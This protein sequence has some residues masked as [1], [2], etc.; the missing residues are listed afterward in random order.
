MKNFFVTASILYLLG[1]KIFAFGFLVEGDVE[2]RQFAASGQTLEESRFNF[3]AKCGPSDWSVT[4]EKPTPLHSF[5]RV[6]GDGTNCYYQIRYSDSTLESIRSQDGVSRNE[7]GALVLGRMVPNYHTYSPMGVIWLTYC[8]SKYFSKFTGSDSRYNEVDVP[9]GEFGNGGEPIELRSILRPAIWKTM[10]STG[11]P[12]QLTILEAGRRR[13]RFQGDGGFLETKYPKP[14][15][16][17][18]TNSAYNATFETFEHGIKLPRSSVYQTYLPKLESAASSNDLYIVQEI[19][20]NT[21]RV[22]SLQDAE[23]L[24]HAFQGVALINDCRFIESPGGVRP[25]LYVSTSRFMSNVELLN[26]AVYKN[27]KPAPDEYEIGGVNS[28]ARRTFYIFLA[29]VAISGVIAFALKR[30]SGRKQQ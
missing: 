22:E 16:N 10:G 23:I 8:S 1:I 21:T 29:L 20:V 25:M 26:S 17:G 5:S 4:I 28:S 2:V 18:F 9:A 30:T 13:G 12:V 19:R 11:L 7:V 27:A 24:P 15:E 14:F 6:S 3:S